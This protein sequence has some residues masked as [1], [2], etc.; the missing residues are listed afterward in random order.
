LCTRDPQLIMHNLAEDVVDFEFEKRRV[1][2]N[3]E[4]TW[5][6]KASFKKYVF[7]RVAG[8]KGIIEHA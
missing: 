1:D 8:P 4:Q 5:V 6:Y 2:T 7:H 3:N